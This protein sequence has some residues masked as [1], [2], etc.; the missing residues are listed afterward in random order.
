MFST[1]TEELA[2]CTVLNSTFTILALWDL[3]SKFGP[4][5]GKEGIQGS[6]K[7]PLGQVEFLKPK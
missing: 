3:E 5:E 4:R 6:L 7:F 1:M 2:M